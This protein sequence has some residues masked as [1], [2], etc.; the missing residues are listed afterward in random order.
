LGPMRI[1]WRSIEPYN[2]AM[3]L[4]SESSYVKM[5]KR[6]KIQDQKCKIVKTFVGCNYQYGAQLMVKS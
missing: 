3:E 6:R 4:D 5:C 2:A 1:I